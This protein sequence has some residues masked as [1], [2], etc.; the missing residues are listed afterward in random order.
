[1]LLGLPVFPFLLGSLLFPVSCS[2]V[3]ASCSFRSSRSS[4]SPRSSGFPC[5]SCSSCSSFL[6]LSL[7]TL[8][9]SLL[10]FLP[11]LCLYLSALLQLVL[12]DCFPFFL[13]FGFLLYF[14]EPIT[15]NLPRNLFLTLTLSFLPSSLY[16]CFLLPSPSASS[17]ILLFLMMMMMK[18]G[19]SLSQFPV[20]IRNALLTAGNQSPTLLPA[21]QLFLGERVIPQG[22]VLFLSG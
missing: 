21:G 15:Q 22:L 19:V 12:R 2:Y 8:P 11:F 17:H 5:S 16:L 20:R 18:L 6:L 3:C 10:A 4:R 9:S 13:C 7:F 1:M 14:H